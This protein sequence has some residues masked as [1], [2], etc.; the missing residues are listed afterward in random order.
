[1]GK[2]NARVRNWL[3]LVAVGLLF[4]AIC[5]AVFGFTHVVSPVTAIGNVAGFLITSL[6]VGF[7]RCVNERCAKG[8]VFARVG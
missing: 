2:S 7:L 1:M 4:A 3:V 5:F 6:V 8:R